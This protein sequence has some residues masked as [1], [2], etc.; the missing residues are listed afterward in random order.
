MLRDHT[1]FPPELLKANVAM[2]QLSRGGRS[3]KQEAR[4][5]CRRRTWSAKGGG[6]EE[7]AGSTRRAAMEASRRA[8]VV[9]VVVVVV[10]MEQKLWELWLWRLCVRKNRHFC[11]LLTKNVPFVCV[12][13]NAHQTPRNLWARSHLGGQV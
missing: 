9:V 8:A 13:L 6:K 12:F 11:V 10:V 7:D 2:A 3:R 5:S 4:E 1:H